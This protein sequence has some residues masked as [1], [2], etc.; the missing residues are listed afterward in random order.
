[1]WIWDDAALEIY[2]K[3]QTLATCLVA[4]IWSLILYLLQ[5][6]HHSVFAVTQFPCC[7]RAHMLIGI[8]WNWATVW[9]E[10]IVSLNTLAP[11]FLKWYLDLK[12]NGSC[13]KISATRPSFFSNGVRMACLYFT[14]KRLL[15]KDIVTC[16]KIKGSKTSTHVFMTDVGIL[17]IGDGLAS[18][19]R[20]SLQTSSFGNVDYVL[21]YSCY[22]YVKCW[23]LC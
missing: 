13:Q 20:I 11:R 19:D 8:C 15:V 4:V 12:L 17:F 6:K 23:S 21:H 7:V 2:P 14:G 1:M 9:H 22:P 18:I 10:P 3:C 16:L 5:G